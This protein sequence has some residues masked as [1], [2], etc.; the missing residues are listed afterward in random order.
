MQ[1]FV[2]RL[3]L[4]VSFEAAAVGVHRLNPLMNGE[5]YLGSVINPFES[6][7]SLSCWCEGGVGCK[8]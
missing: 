6:G 7:E 8:T 3:Q 5:G 2:S 1:F 4:K